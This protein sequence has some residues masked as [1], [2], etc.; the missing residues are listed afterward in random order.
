MPRL[1]AT[2]RWE[3][4]LLLGIPVIAQTARIPM[5]ILVD[6]FSLLIENATFS[7]VEIGVA[8]SVLLLL[9][10]SYPRIRGLGREFLAILWG[11]RIAAAVLTAAIQSAALL[12][13]LAYAGEGSPFFSIGGTLLFYLATA[14]FQI[15]VLLWFARRASRISLPH[16]FFLIALTSFVAP[17]A[18]RGSPDAALAFASMA[19]GAVIALTLALAQVWLLGNFDR[20]D[21][22]FRRNA[23]AALIAAALLSGWAR[24]IV[25]LLLSGEGDAALQAH[26]PFA[27][28]ITGGVAF[29]YQAVFGLALLFAYFALAYLVRERRPAPGAMEG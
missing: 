9:T 18:S 14:P 20:R 15:G 2:Y 11:Y 1:I 5:I 7:V 8:A 26:V 19:V 28:L 10:L 12:M 27:G 13:E 23:I 25:P 22:A 3:L 24:S 21:A 29:A 4:W 6:R 16:A 17:P